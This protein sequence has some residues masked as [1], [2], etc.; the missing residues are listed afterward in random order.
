MQEIQW[1]GSS[2]QVAGFHQAPRD[3]RRPHASLKTQSS[4]E[5]RMTFA[6]CGTQK[7]LKQL[8][9]QSRDVSARQRCWCISVCIVKMHLYECMYLHRTASA[10]VISD[11]RSKATGPVT[12]CRS[13]GLPGP[14]RE[15]M[16]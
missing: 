7:S 1:I 14:A 10:A 4:A 9:S 3:S 2:W 15:E 8:Q 16:S 11:G 5:D 12:S 6:L 13:E